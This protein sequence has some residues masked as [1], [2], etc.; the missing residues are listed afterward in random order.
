MNSD[1]PQ[2]LLFFPTPY[3]D[4]I[5]YSVLC[6]YHS[7]CGSPPAPQTNLELWG[8]RY[9]KRIFL[10]DEIEFF[11]SKIPESANLSAERF[12]S[13]NTI[14]PWLKPF[15]PEE[16]GANLLDALKYGNSNIYNII[17]FPKSIT[18]Q[19]RYLR[20][21]RQCVEH[22]VNQYG[23]AY[24]HR[25]HQLP[26]VRVCPVH[27][28]STVE[29]GVQHSG[30][31]MEYISVP[32]IV[33]SSDELYDEN[34]T[35]QIANLAIDALWLLQNGSTL[36][37]LEHTAA[38]YDRWLRFKWLRSS[39]GKTN[40]KKLAQDLVNYYGKEFLELFG[41]YNSGACSWLRRIIQNS[42]SFQN[43]MFHTLLMRLLAGS[44]ADFFAGISG[45]APV[46]QPYGEP[47]YPCQ[48]ALCEYYLQDVIASAEI[49]KV[50]GIYRAKFECKHCGFAYR[51][52]GP[53]PKEKQY[54][55]QIH[56]ADYGWLWHDKLENMLLEQAS[57]RKI[58]MA[59]KCDTRKVVRIGIKLGF[60]PQEQT[61]KQRTY[62]AHPKAEISFDEKRE[63]YR[64]RWLNAVA[65]NPG[66]TR[67]DLRIIDSKANQWLRQNDVEWYEKNTPPSKS[68]LPKWVD[69]DY[70]NAEK[71]RKAMG[72]IRYYPGKPKR[73]SILALGNA[74]G[75]PKIHR[76]LASG[77]APQTQAA[78]DDCA[79]TLEQWQHRKI[80]WAI[81]QML[82]RGE[83]ITIQKVRHRAT[84]QDKER[85][86][87]RFIAECIETGK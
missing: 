40:R 41:A 62:L 7:R 82:G 55:G 3:P 11:A 68:R 31:H 16:R 42:C 87:D 14:F 6:R 64:K 48:N 32:K 54:E 37:Y 81:A 67:I 76:I 71:I 46:Y 45:E 79:E 27:Y 53:L 84:I 17:A 5:L 18:S 58:G 12:I 51:R 29:S 33:R 70:E 4:E 1:V 26:G 25:A 21:C 49:T 65:S 19:P 10:P 73:I 75:I 61:P 13:R 38:L 77:R 20:Y 56:V 72:Q 66:V 22:D 28:I 35:A 30:L 39:G 9:G 47:P 60:F 24:W 69:D 80:H 23:E 43:P 44:V 34:T 8:K 15:I 59:L 63:H 78:I 50:K 57:L 86:L 36:G 83:V 2:R 74:A 85:K 52:K